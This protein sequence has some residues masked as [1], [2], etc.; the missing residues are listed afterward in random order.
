MRESKN[1]AL[2]TKKKKKK[3]IKMPIGIYNGR[4]RNW[5][6]IMREIYN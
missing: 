6:E 4:I 5:Q 2:S 1:E 3:S